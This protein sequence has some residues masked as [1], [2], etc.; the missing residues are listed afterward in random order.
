MFVE[1]AAAPVAVTVAVVAPAGTG[2]VTV[3]DGGEPATSPEMPTLA[4]SRV[5]VMLLLAGACE[6][7]VMVIVV[8]SP[9]FIGLGGLA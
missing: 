1:P 5:N 9:M 2:T 4:L 8:V 7:K 3:N 6:L